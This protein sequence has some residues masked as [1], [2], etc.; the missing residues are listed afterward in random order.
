MPV[1]RN[2]LIRYKTIDKCLQNRFRKWT[3]NDLIDACSDALYEYEGIDKGVSKRTV[4]ADIQTMR[5]DKLGYNAP[6]IVEDRKYY[7]YADPEYSITNS[8]LTEQDLNMLNE[9][10]EFMK[11]FSNFRHFAQL[12]GMLQKMEDHIHAQQTQTK[13]VIQFEKNDNLKGLEYLD[14]L[15]QAIVKKQALLICYQSFKARRANTF[16]FHPQ[17]LK[18]F[19]NRWFLVGK[20]EKRK[21]V[22][23]LALDRIISLE[24]SEVLYDPLKDF[25]AGLFFKDAIGVSITAG[26]KP[27]NVRLK[28]SPL[29]TPYVKTKPLHHSQT[30]LEEDTNGMEIGLHVVHNFE[31]EKAI[32]AF[33]DHI[34]VIAPAGLRRQIYK[35]L[36]RIAR[37]YEQ[38]DR[39]VDA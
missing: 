35:R 28:V 5:S 33:G 15:Y 38:Q 32:L 1:N 19:R 6:I 8:P 39:E 30:I 10:V 20:R 29:Q 16:D 4:Q 37:M 7:S 14:P 18:E 22:L 25:D 12:G 23:F 31:L 34:R 26:M 9:A 27:I 24:P 2:A 13:P 11:Q 21:A 17:L 3:L 36:S